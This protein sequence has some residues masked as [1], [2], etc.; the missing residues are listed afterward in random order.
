MANNNFDLSNLA[1]QCMAPNN[2]LLY[3]DVGKPSVM[4][5]IPK[6]T[7]AQLGLGTSTDVFPAFIID[8]VE[9]D[10]IYISKYQNIVQ[11]SRAYSLPAQDPKTSINMDAAINACKA[12]GAGWHLMTKVEWALLAW[13]SK[14]NGT[15]P[16]GNNNY[17]KDSRETVYSAIPSCALDS[18]NRI[19]RVATG[20]GPLKWS[21]N[22]QADGIW[23]LNGNVWEWTGGVRTVY[24]EVQLLANN[25]AANSDNSQAASSAQWMAIRASDGVLITPDGSGTTDGSVKMDFISNKLVYSTTITDT[26]RG[27]HSCQFNVITCDNTI[28]DAAK[29][30]LASIGMTR[31]DETDTAF[32]G[33]HFYF[34]NNS[35]ERCF[36]CGASWGSGANA[37]VFYSG[38]TNARSSSNGGIGFR[39]AYY[40]P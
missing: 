29:L 28:S 3:D 39:S 2:E 11:N 6:M 4:V 30:L 36:F 14:K 10:Y 17:G 9:K 34:D 16:Y 23:D 32:D 22:W 12:K 37:G 25:N 13:W 20:T 31:Y 7:Y 27:G 21:H 40:E 5:K 8:G 15:M 33:D 38:G 1:I 24:G 26:A 35:A 18:S 19:Q